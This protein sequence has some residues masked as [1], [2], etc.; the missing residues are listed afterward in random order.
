LYR[1]SR[2]VENISNHAII[3]QYIEE[4]K[5]IIKMFL[6]TANEEFTILKSYTNKFNIY[7]PIFNK[8]REII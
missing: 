1:Q 8:G 3:I 4:Y 7:K 2:D 5:R 6:S